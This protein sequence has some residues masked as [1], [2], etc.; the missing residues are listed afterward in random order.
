M[1]HWDRI[2][3]VK[4]SSVVEEL[5]CWRKDCHFK[6]R[7]LV[8]LKGAGTSGEDKLQC[9]GV[10]VWTKAPL[11]SGIFR[12]KALSA[13]VP[14]PERGPGCVCSRSAARVTFGISPSLFSTPE[15]LIFFFSCFTG[16]SF[17]FPN[18]QPC[19]KFVDRNANLI[20]RQFNNQ[21]CA[22]CFSPLVPS[23]DR[24]FKT[25]YIYIYIRFSF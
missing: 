12:T 16:H 4:S 21:T 13:I 23:E 22:E 20:K 18:H 10:C 8:T 5:H 3:C 24:L 11:R 1:C 2:G 6:A 25:I 17:P 9:L 7:H 14:H 19:P 15:N